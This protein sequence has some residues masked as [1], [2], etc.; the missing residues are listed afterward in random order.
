MTLIDSLSLILSTATLQSSLANFIV[1]DK[2][3]DTAVGML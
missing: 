1:A 2:D 3:C